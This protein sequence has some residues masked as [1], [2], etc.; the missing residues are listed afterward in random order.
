MKATI[1]ITSYFDFDDDILKDYLN[2]CNKKDK[3]PS[4]W[5]FINWV[6]M[7]CDGIDCYFDDEDWEYESVNGSF[8]VEDAFAKEIE[9]IK[10]QND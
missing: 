10:Q 7:D 9:R 2:H 5:D 4:Y 8:E 1:V 3:D 6:Q